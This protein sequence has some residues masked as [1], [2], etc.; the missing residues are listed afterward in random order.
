[1]DI[2]N[3]AMNNLREAK[4]RESDKLAKLVENKNL[5]EEK[6]LT[7]EQINKIYQ[8]IDSMIESLQ[9]EEE[10]GFNLTR[11]EAIKKVKETFKDSKTL[12]DDSVLYDLIPE[13]DEEDEGEI[14]DE[15]L[16]VGNE[17]LN[18]LQVEDNEEVT[19][20]DVYKILNPENDSSKK[21]QIDLAMKSLNLTPED[22][23]DLMKRK[24]KI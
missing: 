3:K 6:T 20:E 21:I 15:V 16:R 12:G 1:M 8:E 24:G 14:T 5:N 13:E 22:Y 4:K 10:S 2:L 7:Q 19:I 23:L 18:S 9:D 17:Y 11:E